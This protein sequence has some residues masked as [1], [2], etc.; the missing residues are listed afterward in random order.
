MLK[1]VD[2]ANDAAQDAFMEYYLSEKEFEN[3]EHIKAWLLR[4]TV[5]KAKDMARSF[6]R[7]NMV[8]LEQ[9]EDEVEFK[10]P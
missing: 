4:V 7:R 1:N 3:E 10:N 6:F 9:M 8:P 5:N 2:D